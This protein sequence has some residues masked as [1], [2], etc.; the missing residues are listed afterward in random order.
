MYFHSKMAWPPNNNNDNNN[1]KKKN[2]NNNDFITVFPLKGSSS[3]VKMY[4]NIKNDN[5]NN[6]N[7]KL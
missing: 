6:I 1:K 5:N 3:S 4:I 7:K 2:K